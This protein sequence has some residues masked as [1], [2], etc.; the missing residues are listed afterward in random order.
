MSH[1]IDFV[2]GYV[3]TWPG[4]VSTEDA[5]ARRIAIEEDPRS[6]EEIYPTVISSAS[7]IDLNDST[8]VAAPVRREYLL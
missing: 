5:I 3:R 2:S 8:A 4:Y 1:Y 7:Q 6:W